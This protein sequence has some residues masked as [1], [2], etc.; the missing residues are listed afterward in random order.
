MDRVYYQMST[1]NK[2]FLRAYKE[3]KA[4]GFK[5]N[6]FMLRLLDRDLADVDPF[7]PKLDAYMKARIVQEATNNIFYFLRELVKFDCDDIRIL[8]FIYAM[9]AGYSTIFTHE[10]SDVEDVKTAVSAFFVFKLLT[11]PEINYNAIAKNE[12]NECLLRIQAIK[13]SLPNYFLDITYRKDRAEVKIFNSSIR[14]YPRPASKMGA[15]NLLRGS[16]A[17]ALFLLGCQ[18]IKCVD[19]LYS[20]AIPSIAIKDGQF[21]ITSSVSN[22]ETQSGRFVYMMKTKGASEWF[23]IDSPK[24]VITPVYI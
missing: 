20:N 21:V 8:K 15:E 19:I 18:D 2:S 10:D 13:D 23:D 3:L 12:E 7:D 6:R 14:F 24:K 4:K 5:N 11:D 17:T 1:K 22:C 9:R 16:S